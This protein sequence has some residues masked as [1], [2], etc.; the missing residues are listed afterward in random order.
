VVI[1][2]MLFAIGVVLRMGSGAGF[3]SRHVLIPEVSWALLIALIY[4]VD[5]LFNK[6]LVVLSD[7]PT[8]TN[9]GFNVGGLNFLTGAVLP[10]RSCCSS[11]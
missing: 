11:R 9:L 10:A 7:K 3:L 8:Y 5:D 4:L 6:Q 1:V 2:T